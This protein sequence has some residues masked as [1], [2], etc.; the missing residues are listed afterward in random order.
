MNQIKYY[1]YEQN[2]IHLRRQYLKVHL[3]NQLQELIETRDPLRQH[4]QTLRKIEAAQRL[5][6]VILNTTMAQERIL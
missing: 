3:L 6:N 2:S 4:T 1:Y 5:A